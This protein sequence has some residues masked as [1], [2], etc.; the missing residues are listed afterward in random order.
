V[1]ADDRELK[2]LYLL[3]TGAF[4]PT[5][6]AFCR[7]ESYSETNAALTAKFKLKGQLVTIKRVNQELGKQ[8]HRKSVSSSSSS[9]SSQRSSSV[10]MSEARSSK[11][12]PHPP[13]PTS[14]TILVGLKRVAIN[15][16][17]KSSLG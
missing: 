5:G 9:S 13:G 2:E 6:I 17:E 1:F 14:A 11:S 15:L 7:F 16:T 12:S 3:R 4:E 10:E 8:Q